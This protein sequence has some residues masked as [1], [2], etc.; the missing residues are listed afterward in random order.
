MPKQIN[1]AMPTAKEITKAREICEANEL[2]D[3]YGRETPMARWKGQGWH[4]SEVL[5]GIFIGLQIAETRKNAKKEQR[6]T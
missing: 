6:T 3:S 5:F 1:F 2:D 4:L